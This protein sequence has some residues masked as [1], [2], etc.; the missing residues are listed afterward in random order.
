MLPIRLR[1]WT[2][3]S[4]NRGFILHQGGR[5]EIYSRAH[6]DRYAYFLPLSD[7]E[8]VSES[9]K[10]LNGNTGSNH[11]GSAGSNPGGNSGGVGGGVGSGGGGGNSGSSQAGFA[12]KNKPVVKYGPLSVMAN[13]AAKV[14]IDAK[15][16]FYQRGKALVRPVVRPVQTFD[17]KMTSAA[18][19]VEV[20]LPYLRDMLCKNSCWVKYDGRSKKWRDIHPPVDAAQVLL[21]RFGDWDFPEIAGIITTPTLRP[22]GTILQAAGYDPATQLLLIDPPAMPD[23]PEQTD[24]ARTHWRRSTCSTTCWSSFLSRMW[25]PTIKACRARWGCRR[26]SRRCAAAPIPWCRCTSSTRRR[27]ASGKSYLLST[28]SRIATGQP[29]PVLGA[30]KSE[31]ELEKRLGAAVIHGQSLVCID[32]VVGEIGGDALCRLI[33]QPRPTYGSSGNPRMSRLTPAAPPILPMAT[34]SPSS[35]TCAAG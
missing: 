4:R 30:G 35:A 32:N 12:G 26:L 13:D 10:G 16:P 15:V 22:D 17:G 29:M 5:V 28:V 27:P 9:L 25:T 14:L 31:E 18:Q 11:G 33:E 20:E 8:D 21:K 7:E 34:T 6:G 3:R 23:I 1:A 19:L 2:T 24:R